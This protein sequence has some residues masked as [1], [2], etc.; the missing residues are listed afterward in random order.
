MATFGGSGA[1]DLRGFD[2]VRDRIYAGSGNDTLRGLGG[3]DKLVGEGG[4]DRL[5]GGTGNDVLT[6]DGTGKKTY[7]DV[8]VFGEDSG[9]DV[10]TDFQVGKDMLEIQKGLNGINKASD[11]LDHATQKGNSVIIDLGDGNTIK[12]KNVDLDDLKKNPNDHFDITGL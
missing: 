8:F 10:I 2:G 12:L 7:A 1:D 11:V 5:D 3:N 9:K 4:K 6:G